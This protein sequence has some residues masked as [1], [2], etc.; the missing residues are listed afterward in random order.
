MRS[1]R[2]DGVWGALVVL[3]GATL[4]IVVLGLAGC[5]IGRTLKSAER[6]AK[7]AVPTSVAIV[8][9]WPFGIAYAAIGGGA[10]AFT[11]HLLVDSGDL[12]AGE[13]VGEEAL[14]KELARA[15]GER[16]AARGVVRSLTP[17]LLSAD[18][19]RLWA[20]RALYFLAILVGVNLLLPRGRQG[21]V[22]RWRKALRAGNP[23]MVLASFVW[24]T[25]CAVFALIGS[26]H[27]LPP[28]KRTRA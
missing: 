6:P 21:L 25:I 24:Q 8:L 4:M 14:R 26:G 15:Y 1:D 23:L 11:S 16:D 19:W 18:W 5:G 2:R 22:E 12:Q 10:V 13:I 27:S 9:L 28:E 20:W 7:V 3:L 17:P